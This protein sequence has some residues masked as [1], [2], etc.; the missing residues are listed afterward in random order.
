MRPLFWLQKRKYGE[1]LSSALVWARS[2]KLFLALS[3]L[4]GA[5]DRKSSPIDPALRA[6]ITV[7]VSQINNCEFC[8][9]INSSLLLKRGVTL[10]KVKALSEWKK[11]KLFNSRE[12]AA[13]EYA[14]LVTITK[15][16]IKDVTFDTLKT[17][18]NDDEIVELTGL[19]AFQNMSSKFNA[20]LDIPSQGFCAVP[21]PHKLGARNTKKKR[22]KR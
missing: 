15:S 20:S 3:G 12:K 11:S 9:D 1:I 6:L 7:R 13:L 5:L 10:A 14:E 2:P 17:Y 19:I 22:A 21:A 8:I 16:K 4:Y 18:F